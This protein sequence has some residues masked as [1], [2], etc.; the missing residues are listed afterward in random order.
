MKKLITLAVSML[1]SFSASA[2]TTDTARTITSIGAQG[3]SAYLILTP[4]PSLAS[5]AYG[6]V[7]LDD[8][9][10]AAGKALYSTLLTAY[11]Q[12]KALERVDYAPNG[13][14]VCVISLIQVGA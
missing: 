14:G 11:S 6:L 1:I 2:L 4:A 3:Q 7:Y 12:G 5:C 9:S 8:L 10:T 13:A